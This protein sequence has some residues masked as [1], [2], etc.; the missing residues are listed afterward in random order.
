MLQM[1][2]S[3]GFLHDIWA[4]RKITVVLEGKTW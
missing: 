4:Q 2:N 1:E 3:V